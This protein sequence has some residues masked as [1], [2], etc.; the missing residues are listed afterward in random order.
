MIVPKIANK[1]PQ[2]P[3]TLSADSKPWKL[4]VYAA[5]ILIIS[6]VAIPSSAQGQ[7]RYPP[8]SEYLMPQDAE[9]ELAQSAQSAGR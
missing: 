6:S 1:M 3:L 7:T 8:L 5:A 2:R 4:V 9:I